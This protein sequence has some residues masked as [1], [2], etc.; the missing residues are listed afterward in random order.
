MK[1]KRH[2][3]YIPMDLEKLTLD[4]HF[5]TEALTS[6]ISKQEPIKIKLIA[7]E[8]IEETGPPPNFQI[9]VANGQLED[10]IGTVLLELEVAD[11]ML[12]E[13]FIFM[14]N[15]PNQLIGLCFLSKNNAIFDVT[16]GIL[17]FPYPSMHPK[18]DTQTAIRQATP[19]FAENTYTLQPG[20]TIAIASET[21][22]LMDH[23]ATGI[24]A[25]TTT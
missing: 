16:Q 24:V 5:D 12:K 23:D 4:G 21:P 6:A 25:I 2:L 19:L 8:A 14:K 20:E 17:F 13:N 1:R 7:S 9:M 15:L 10:P 22:H 3:Y 18:P 11:F